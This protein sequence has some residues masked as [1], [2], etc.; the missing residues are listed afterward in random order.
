M[1]VEELSGILHQSSPFKLLLACSGYG[2]IGQ[3]CGSLSASVFPF[4]QWVRRSD[5]FSEM[6]KQAS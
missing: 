1:I 4:L 3:I 2:D 5:R 6:L